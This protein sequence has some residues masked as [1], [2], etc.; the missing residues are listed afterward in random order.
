MASSESNINAL[1]LGI[2]RAAEDAAYWPS[3]LAAICR[4]VDGSGAAIVHQDR[5]LSGRDVNA[6][7]GFGADTIRLYQQHYFRVDPWGSRLSPSDWIP[8]R[9][10]DGQ[11]IVPAAIVRSG[12]WFAG[13]GSRFDCA[14]S[15]MAFL[16]PFGARVAALTVNRGA[17][18]RPF[19]GR[20]AILLETLAPHLRQAFRLHRRLVAVDRRY[21]SAENLLD[22]LP[23]GII[24]LTA[25]RRRVFLNGLAERLLQAGDGL[26]AS[27]DLVRGTTA[28]D[29]DRI[30]GAVADALRLARGEVV[31]AS[32]LAFG[33]SRPSGRGMLRV[34][35]V[36]ATR[37]SL[38]VEAAL[39][40]AVALFISESDVPLV[41]DDRLLRALFHLT[42]T[43]GRVAM[44]LVNGEGTS[45]IASALEMGLGTARWHVKRILQKADVRTQA[46]FVTR[47]LGSPAWLHLGSE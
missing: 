13:F 42:A 16:E 36:P 17:A 21:A 1:I 28:H 8:G 2:Y 15:L 6:Y 34:V 24:L 7:T 9:V 29:T 47:V 37:S 27:G 22:R 44:R 10:R 30:A 14:H 25:T 38:G 18:Q 31:G 23:I 32:R 45:D 3:A 4:A 41:R 39:D 46:Q 20:D 43:E 33:L 5:A 35:A 26:A 12:E 40:A 19:D 11:S